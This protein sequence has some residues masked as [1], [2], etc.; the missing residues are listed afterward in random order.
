[1]PASETNEEADESA[2]YVVRGIRCCEEVRGVRAKMETDPVNYL[3]QL[4]EQDPPN[5]RL[6]RAA[7][8]LAT[9]GTPDL[10]P[11]PFLDQLN[12]MASQLADRMRNFND[13]RD[14]VETAQRYLF[15]ELGFH[16]NQQDFFD[17]GNSFL[18]QVLERRTGIPITLSVMYMEI[19]RRLAMPVFGIGLPRHFVIQFDDGN[20]STYIDPYHGGRTITVQECFALAGAKVADPILLRRASKKQIA[21]RMLQNL[22]G[23]Y[24]R[25]RDWA[26]A[27]DT[28]DLLL[29]GAPELSGLLK[30]RGLLHMELKRFQAARRDLERYLAMEPAAADR[31][32][33]RKQIRAIH[34]WLARVN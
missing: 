12:E 16:G 29:L 30:Q 28:L 4:L 15:G 13:G 25:R 19:A 18:N 22:R 31:E 1:L 11:E 20:Y 7:L 3:R 6:D 21:M 23:V 34:A 14:F 2:S 8:E 17:P 5:G 10:Q 24:L 27:V 26:R 9:L 32:E 33:I